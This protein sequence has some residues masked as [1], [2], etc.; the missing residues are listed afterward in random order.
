MFKRSMELHD[1]V[2]YMKFVG[3]G[4]SKNYATILG[5]NPYSP[6]VV[7]KLECIGHVG[8][9]M[10]SR[11]RSLR[12][13]NKLGG[14]GSIS[15]RLINS[16]QGYYTKAI[17]D[18]LDNLSE[19]KKAI[20]AIYYHILSDDENPQHEYCPMKEDTWCKYNRLIFDDLDPSEYNH[21]N[22]VRKEVWKETKSIFCDL[23]KDDL[24]EKCVKGFRQNVNECFNS[25]V[26]LMCPKTTYSSIDSVRLGMYDAVISYVEVSFK[27]KRKNL[28]KI[29]HPLLP[30]TRQSSFYV[31]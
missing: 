11:L 10:G 1:N 22:I 23:S 31:G 12:I 21:V 2:R 19:M 24:L 26:W 25:L 4:D 15:K 17:C 27:K 9:R 16:V 20:L 18:N 7:E 6:D 30:L 28:K 29:N 3:D 14:K 5:D 8:K 13:K